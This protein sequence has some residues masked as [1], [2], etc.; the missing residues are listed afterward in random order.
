VRVQLAGCL[1]EG[2][3][4]AVAEPLPAAGDAAGEAVG[5]HSSGVPRLTVPAG[6]PALVEDAGDLAVGVSGEQ[7]GDLL[8][9]RLGG[10]ALLPGVE[11]DRQVQG[12]ALA[13]Q[14]PDAG[15]LLLVEDGGFSSRTAVPALPVV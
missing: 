4:A 10:F 14:C 5:A 15:A 7:L 6:Q 11:R 13:G 12:A 2:E 1:V 8:D 3:Q 9:H